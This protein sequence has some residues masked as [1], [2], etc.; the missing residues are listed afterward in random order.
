MRSG[1]LA[2][3]TGVSTDT[4]RHYERLGLLPLPQ[5]TA[6]NYREYP[7]TSPQRV[8]LIRRALTIG[9]SLPE[10]KAILALRDKGGAPC[11]HVRDLLRS[12]IHKLDQQIRNLAS[13]RAEMNRQSGS[14]ASCYE[15]SR[16]RKDFRSCAR[17][18][19]FSCWSSSQLW[20]TLNRIH[21]RTRT[22]VRKMSSSAARMR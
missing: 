19:F 13:L 11:R 18:S 5:R 7:A 4:L 10:L 6:G 9:F 20:Q 15:Y 21:R 8:E 12:K 22:N 2:R 16:R 17:C 14:G 3:Q 1:Q